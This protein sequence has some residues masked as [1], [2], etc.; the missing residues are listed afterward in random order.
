MLVPEIALTPQ[1]VHRFAGRFPG[2]VAVLH[3]GLSAASA[4]TSGGRSA[5]GG[6]DIVVGSRSAVFAPLP[7]LGLIIVDEEH[8]WSYKQDDTRRA[9]TPATWPCSRAALT[10]AVVVL[11]SATPDVATYHRATR[12]RREDGPTRAGRDTGT[13]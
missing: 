1:T 8:E 4:T 2:R 10:G 9:T 13:C 7:R 11:G 12:A 5:T 3:S 6:Y